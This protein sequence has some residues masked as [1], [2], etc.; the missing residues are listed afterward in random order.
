MQSWGTGASTYMRLSQGNLY[1]GPQ[2]P[3]STGSHA[4]ARLSVDGKVLAK[5]LFINIQTATWADYVFDQNYNLLSLQEVEQFIKKHK[6]LPNVPSGQEL[7]GEEYNLNVA[8]M[9]KIQMEKIEEAFLHLIALQKEI[10]LLKEE[11]KQLKRA[12]CEN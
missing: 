11:N 3:N 5:E 12:L 10:E 4:N 8:E 2:V 9:H 1:I 6:H 7:D